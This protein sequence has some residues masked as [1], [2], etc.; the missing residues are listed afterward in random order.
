MDNLTPEV[1]ASISAAAAAQAAGAAAA[2]YAQAIANGVEQ[3]EASIVAEDAGTNTYNTVIAEK[4]AAANVAGTD[5]TP[6][7]LLQTI[8]SSPAL[9]ISTGLLIIGVIRLFRG[10]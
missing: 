9:T 2:A 1:S 5:N 8:L 10:K 7:N 6:K 4:T 3:N